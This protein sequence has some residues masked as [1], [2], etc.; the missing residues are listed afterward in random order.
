[1]PDLLTGEKDATVT[2]KRIY[3]LIFANN[4]NLQVYSHTCERTFRE[5]YLSV[6]IKW[7][8]F[9]NLSFAAL[10][11]N[12][13]QQTTWMLRHHVLYTGDRLKKMYPLSNP[14]CRSCYSKVEDIMHAFVLCSSVAPIW[15]HF[16]NFFDK[17]LH[18]HYQ[19]YQLALGTFVTDC[20][21]NKRSR[22]ALTLTCIINYAIWWQ[23]NKNHHELKARSK[24]SSSMTVKVINTLLTG[25][26]KAHFD[27][28]KRQDTLRRFAVNFCIE[29]A[30]CSLSTN[31]ELQ[32]HF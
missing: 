32:L 5:N 10:C 26:L 16:S 2:N 13:M 23:R 6:N 4:K 28:H 19:H 14:T 15:G 31:M 7:K 9:W 18:A 20:D 11:P 24:I 30:L 12:K 17:I 3:N 22:L 29:S 1:M 21:C 25:I 27:Y 8:N